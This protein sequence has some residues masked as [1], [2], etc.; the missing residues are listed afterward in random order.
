[1]QHKAASL[2]S[3]FSV[4]PSDVFFFSPTPP[5]NINEVPIEQLGQQSVPQLEFAAFSVQV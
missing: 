3:A 4:F 1:M 2:A 5:P